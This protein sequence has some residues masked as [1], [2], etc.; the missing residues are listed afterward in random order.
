MS[1]R[2]SEVPLEATIGEAAIIDISDV[3]PNEEITAERLA[4]RGGD[5]RP[6]DI[7][8]IKTRWDEKHS[9]DTPEF[10][11]ESPYLSRG[12]C[13]WLL[14]TGLKAMSPDFPQDYPIHGLLKG[15]VA[16]IEDFV[17]HD[18]LLR[19]GVI[20]IEYVDNFGALTGD[21]TFIYA[22]PLC[23]PDSDGSPARVIAVV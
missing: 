3:A 17:S 12:A 5:V 13:E 6:G 14:S 23:L 9:L 2:P 1:L 16:P 19:N 10:W 11:T 20:L 22:L 8:L 18:V 4:E 15:E 21:R 7:V